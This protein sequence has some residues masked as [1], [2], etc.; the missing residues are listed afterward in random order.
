MI[1]TTKLFED[2]TVAQILDLVE[3]ATNKKAK[4]EKFITRFSKYYT[5][6]VTI[7]ALLLAVF[8]PVFL[9]QNWMIWLERA[10]IFLVVSCPCVLVISVPMGFFGG[11]GAASQK[12][13]LVKGSN[14]LEILSEV[15]TIVFDKTGT[16][17][18]GVF[19]V[20]DVIPSS[21]IRS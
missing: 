11:I 9:Q 5:P 8:P 2:S 21:D 1:K 16:L 17:T 12:G 20:T 19:E 15:D 4:V 7:S 6:F 18:N 10:C 13:V 14:Y 3:N